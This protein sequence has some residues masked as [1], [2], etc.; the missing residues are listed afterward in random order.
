[1][2]AMIPASGP[3]QAFVDR[4]KTHCSA[5]GRDEDLVIE[6]NTQVS[7]ACPITG[8]RA[9]I[10]CRLRDCQGLA[11]FDLDNF[12]QLVQRTR[13][14][15]CPHCQKS[16][17]PSSLIIDTFLLSLVRQLDDEGLSDVTHIELDYDGNWRPMQVCA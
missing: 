11:I 4:A 7:L 2:R 6:S 12:L 15:L 13:K 10:P 3:M 9:R 8:N 17:D 1:M 14:W 16:G 5:F